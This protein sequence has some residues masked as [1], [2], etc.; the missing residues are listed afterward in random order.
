[1]G[2]DTTTAKANSEGGNCE[3]SLIDAQQ[4]WVI[5][6]ICGNRWVIRRIVL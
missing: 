2:A 6:G 5:P 4:Q 1:M 3:Q